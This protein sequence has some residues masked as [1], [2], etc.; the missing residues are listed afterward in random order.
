MIITYFWTEQQEAPTLCFLD[1][2][3]LVWKTIF[4][5]ILPEYTHSKF[6]Q[7]KQKFVPQSPI[8]KQM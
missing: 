2:G 3:P 6:T 5:C 7:S 8:S 1:K 4:Y